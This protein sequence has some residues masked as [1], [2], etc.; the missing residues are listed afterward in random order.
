MSCFADVQYCS[1]KN[2]MKIKTSVFGMIKQDSIQTCGIITFV[3]KQGKKNCYC[4][5][6]SIKFLVNRNNIL[7]LTHSN[8]ECKFYSI[9][10][11]I[12]RK[13]EKARKNE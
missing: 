13:S 8:I 3:T 2:V 6:K 5:N 9:L 4:D 7:C 10:N 11:E 12:R 1:S